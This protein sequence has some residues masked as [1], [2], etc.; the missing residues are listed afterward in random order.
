[1]DRGRRARGTSDGKKLEGAFLEIR[2]NSLGHTDQ[3][4]AVV[5][6]IAAPLSVTVARTYGNLPMISLK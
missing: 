3:P 5:T 4:A 1:M 2:T 6:Q